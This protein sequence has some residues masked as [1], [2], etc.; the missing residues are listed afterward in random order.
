ME[1]V[2]YS[3]EETAEIARDFIKDL[4]SKENLATII[5]LYGELG[6]GKTTFM[7]YVAEAFG[8]KETVQ[9]PTFVIEKIY[10][11]KG[12][13]EKTQVQGFTH[14]IHI[15]AYRIEKEEEMVNLGWN[16]II[17]D[18]KNLICVEW[19]ERIAGIMGEHLKIFFEHS[20][21]LNEQERKIKIE[22]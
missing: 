7:K 16:E 1:F 9:S 22:K 21:N 20:E 10:E 3:V 8:I 18:N 13:S 6:A 5:G 12:A 19:P 2:S 15:D 14:L 11:L 4:N 17:A